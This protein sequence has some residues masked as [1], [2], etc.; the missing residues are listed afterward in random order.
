MPQVNALDKSGYQANIFFSYVIAPYLKHLRE[1][2]QIRVD[3]YI[4]AL[5]RCFK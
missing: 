5:V 4:S 2:F 3:I 1:M